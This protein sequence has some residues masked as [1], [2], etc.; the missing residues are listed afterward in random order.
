MASR[1]RVLFLCSE[2]SCRSQM[3][4]G[5]LRHLGGDGFEVASAGM[6][7]DEVD[8]R[9]HRVMA[10]IGIDTTGHCSKDIAELLGR[11]GFHYVVIVCDRA[12]RL[13]PTVWP[14]V[15]ERLLWPF[16]DP[17]AAEGTPE[18]QTEVFRRVR[19]EI[20]EKLLDWMPSALEQ[21]G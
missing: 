18:E 19:D 10:E 6:E 7:P 21:D 16:D 17:R 5:L 15:H 14:G 4:E 3:A 11:A 13:C 9:V 12:A 1:I 20:R 2:N 8:P